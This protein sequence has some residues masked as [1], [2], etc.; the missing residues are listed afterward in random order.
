[1]FAERC[2]PVLEDYLGTDLDPFGTFGPGGIQPME[3]AWNSGDRSM[4]C[5]VSKLSPPD[6]TQNY[7]VMNAFTGRVAELDQSLVYPNGTCLKLEG[8]G[9]PVPCSGP[10]HFEVVSELDLRDLSGDRPS[11]DELMIRC[12]VLPREMQPPPIGSLEAGILGFDPASWAAGSRR[13]N[14]IAVVWDDNGEPILLTG[15]LAAP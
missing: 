13:G 12:G 10:H 14:C 3:A 2:S 9:Q 8:R 11:D 15:P 4:W 6:Q 7:A 1:L 5:G